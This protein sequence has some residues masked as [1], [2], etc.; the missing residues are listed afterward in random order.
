MAADEPKPRLI[1]RLLNPATGKY[2][3]SKSR[4]NSES[5]TK[6]TQPEEPPILDPTTGKYIVKPRRSSES[7]AQDNNKDSD[8]VIRILDPS[9]G[10]Y[11]T[12]SRRRFSESLDQGILDFTPD[13][14]P[15]TCTDHNN[16]RITPDSDRLLISAQKLGLGVI[17]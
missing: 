7:C 15:N 3:S 8:D 9:T 1:S 6:S 17:N 16:R 11:I 14:N 5:D 4:R 10:S 12:K 13:A 2:F